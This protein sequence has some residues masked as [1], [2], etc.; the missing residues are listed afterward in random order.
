[1]TNLPPGVGCEGLILPVTIRPH[2]LPRVGRSGEPD[3]SPSQERPLS[4]SRRRT[5][6]GLRLRIGRAWR[7]PENMSTHA[8]FVLDANGSAMTGAYD[9]AENSTCG[10]RAADRLDRKVETCVRWSP[11]VRASSAPIS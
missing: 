4:A 8:P 2:D 11:V 5:A 6:R 3:V 10:L 9:A 7:L 1:M